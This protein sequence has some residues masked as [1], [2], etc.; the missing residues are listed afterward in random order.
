MQC[1]AQIAQCDPATSAICNDAVHPNL[2]SQKRNLLLT[3]FLGQ[4]HAFAHT[5]GRTRANVAQLGF[6]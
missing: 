2:T 3:I 6:E 4:I 5:A 1:Q